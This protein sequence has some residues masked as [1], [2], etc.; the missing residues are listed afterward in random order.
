MG[1][2]PLVFAGW[3]LLVPR[4]GVADGHMMPA[5][6]GVDVHVEGSVAQKLHPIQKACHLQQTNIIN[7]A[8]SL[9]EIPFLM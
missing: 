7:T 8:L 4:L 9:L 1:S 5:Q 2:L 3:L 6:G